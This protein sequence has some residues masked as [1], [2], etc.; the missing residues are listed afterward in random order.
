MPIGKVK[1]VID[2][3]TF[4]LK[5]GEYVRISGLNAPEM[6][7]RGGPSAK[8]RLQSRIP[9]G[10]QVGLSLPLA[11][12]YGRFVRKVTVDGKDIN[13]LVA[14]PKSQRRK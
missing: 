12:S 5:G 9:T 7:Q 14:A 13:K 8:H 11:K 3:D 4:Q 10:T 1:R 2:G 6:N